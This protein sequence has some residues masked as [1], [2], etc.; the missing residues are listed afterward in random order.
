MPTYL[1]CIYEELGD[2][3]NDSCPICNV[4]LGCLPLE[5]LR[6]DHQLDD[7]CAKLSPVLTKRK[8]GSENNADADVPAPVRRKERSLLSLGIEAR[9]ASHQSTAGK[10]LKLESRSSVVSKETFTDDDLEQRSAKSLGRMLDNRAIQEQA[11]SDQQAPSFESSESLEGEIFGKK[12]LL[13]DERHSDEIS[14][15]QSLRKERSPLGRKAILEMSPKSSR[16]LPNV[17]SSVGKVV[18]GWSICRSGELQS[19]IPKSRNFSDTLLVKRHGINGSQSKTVLFTEENF[20]K[21]SIDESPLA[22]L[23]EVAVDQAEKFEYLDGPRARG[24]RA[25]RGKSKT[26]NGKAFAVGASLSWQ[27]MLE[28]IRSTAAPH[29]RRQKVKSKSSLKAATSPTA[30]HATLTSFNKHVQSPLSAIKHEDQNIG[31][32]FSLEAADNQLGDN[33]LP[34]IPSRYLRIRDGKLPVS[35]VKKYLV[36]KLD[37]QSEAEVEIACRGQPV[38]PSLPLEKVKGIWL[39]TVPSYME[40]LP[41]LKDMNVAS[42]GSK[43]W[44]Q[45]KGCSA[46]KCVMVLTYSRHRHQL[47]T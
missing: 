38:V 37:L 10:Q 19:Q 18:T 43:S 29:E 32:W 39:A 5:K 16:A 34:Q 28:N 11:G 25:R 1:S 41:A 27:T 3:E 14:L 4:N 44:A 6:A 35:S 21:G 42:Q 40:S 30:T 12:G 36:K 24:P 23:A 20:E 22:C 13:S 8:S 31:F 9:S 33:P 47:D 15:L 2:G 17:G 26:E 7:V 45:Y 46:E